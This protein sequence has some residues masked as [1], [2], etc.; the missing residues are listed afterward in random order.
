LDVTMAR[1]F[2]LLE[3]PVGGIA[4]VVVVA[5]VVFVVVVGL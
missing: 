5:V 2:S 4:A 1:R 3:G